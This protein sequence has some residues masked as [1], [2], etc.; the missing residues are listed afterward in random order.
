MRVLA[1]RRL[2]L[3]EVNTEGL[4]SGHEAFEPLDLWS[5]SRERRVGRTCRGLQVVDASRADSGRSRSMT[6]LRMVLTPA[7]IVR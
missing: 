2:V 5:N 3:R 7:S 6:Y 4:V 1:D